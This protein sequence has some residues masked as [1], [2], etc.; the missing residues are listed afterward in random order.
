[1]NKKIE[2]KA[3]VSVN[4]RNAQALR[5]AKIAVNLLKT[6][7]NEAL[8]DMLT[9]CTKQ[10]QIIDVMCKNDKNVSDIANVLLSRN[11]FTS[12][13]YAIKRVKRHIKKD[14]VTAIAKRHISI[15]ARA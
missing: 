3:I 11:M 5:T 8:D 13:D 7:D 10:N 2:R 9:H 14:R 4:K 15:I 12:L 1:M 6:K